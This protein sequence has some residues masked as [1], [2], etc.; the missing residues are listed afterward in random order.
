MRSTSPWETAILKGEGVAHCK[1]KGHLCKSGWTDRDAIWVLG[2]DGPKQSCIGWGYRSHGKGNFKG[3]KGRPLMLSRVDPRNHV[4]D[5]VQIPHGKGQIWGEEHAQTYSMTLWCELCKSSWT[6]VINIPFGLWT[7]LGPRKH[8]LHGAQIPHVKGQL[9]GKRTC[10]GMPNDTLP[11]AVQ[12]W[13][14]RSICYLGCALKWAKGST[15]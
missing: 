11:S 9:L 7:Q 5:G 6:N 14:N 3:R 13:L 10:P 4:L 1:V 8:V 15:S 2:S 12:K